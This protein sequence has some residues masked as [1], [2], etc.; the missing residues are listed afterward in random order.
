M[1]E[2]GSCGHLRAVHN[3]KSMKSMI[4]KLCAE[5]K[6]IKDIDAIAFRGVSG[7]AVAYPIMYKT[8]IPVVNIRKEDS[9][10]RSIE[11]PDRDIKKYIIVDDLIDSGATIHVIVT[12]MHDRGIHPT[13]CKGILLYSSF[14]TQEPFVYD[15]TNTTIPIYIL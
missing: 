14:S 3:P 7:A 13:N 2:F 5:I 4:N 11:G 9:H 12:T 8:G 15:P 1:A 6:T 10:G